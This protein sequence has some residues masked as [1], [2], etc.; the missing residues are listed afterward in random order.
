MVLKPP[1]D[2]YPTS[3]PLGVQGRPA[4]QGRTKGL[5]P[6]PEAPP[7]GRA[8]LGI[9]SAVLAGLHLLVPLPWALARKETSWELPWLV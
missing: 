1:K 9:S 6:P 7:E 2:P 3:S 8:G 5:R 4:R